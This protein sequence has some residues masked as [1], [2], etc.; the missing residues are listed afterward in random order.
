M[1]KRLVSEYHIYFIVFLIFSVFYN[2]YGYASLSTN[3]DWALRGMLVAKGVYNTFIMSY[4]L[5]WV[6]SH[7]Y[8][9]FPLIPWY[10]ILLSL[11]MIINF[12]FVARYIAQLDSSFQKIVFLI[13]SVLWITF[14]WF[15]MSITILTVTTM[16]SAVG[17]IKQRFGVSL[18]LLFVAALL[19]TD[20]MFI[21]MPYYIASYLILRTSWQLS[22]SEIVHI[23]LVF[24]MLIGMTWMEKRDSNYSEW[25]KFNKA[26]SAIVDM[27]IMDVSK[28]YFTEEEQFFIM[29]SWWQD[30]MLLPMEKV[31]AVTPTLATVLK[32]NLKGIHPI[33]FIQNYKFKHWLW[34][35]LI[36][37]IFLF[38]IKF[39]QQKVKALFIPVFV[40]GVLLLLITRDVERV[41]VPLIMMWAYLLFESLRPYRKINTLLLVIFTFIFYYYASNQLGYRYYKENTI[42]QK[43]ARELIHQS[44]KSCEPSMI[45]PLVFS[46]EVNRVFQANYL[47]DENNWLQMNDNE[48]LPA[49]WLVRHPYFY[50]AHQISTSDI[51][52]KYQDYHEYLVDESTAFFGS[53]YLETNKVYQ[54]YLLQQ[55]DRLYLQDRPQCHHNVTV[56]SRSKHFSIAQIR[57]ECDEKK[58]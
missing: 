44:G 43:E 1:F 29:I 50:E 6:V 23:V 7:L 28:N 55:Y 16:I 22:K 24:I 3:D 52:R 14:L 10:S 53:K 56:I 27:G 20:I 57:I 35:L 39:R 34:L 11:V 30:T 8:D 25:L 54:K 9:F 47:F 15:N 13:L 21:M 36:A 18:L 37:S 45:F 33:K 17:M 46:N 49:G 32:K 41:T 2:V 19:R 4:P 26:R 12:Y 51:H 58:K 38:V 5:S 48:I 31:I 42:L 40:I